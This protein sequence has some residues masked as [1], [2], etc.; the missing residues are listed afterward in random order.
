MNPLFDNTSFL[1]HVR[2][3]VSHKKETEEN[4]VKKLNQ[5][6]YQE[7]IDLKKARKRADMANLPLYRNIGFTVAFLLVIVV[8]NWRSPVD[9][10]VDLGTLEVNAEE[11]IDIPISEQ[12]PPPPPKTTEV[13]RIVEVENSVELEELELIIDVEAKEESEVEVI[14]ADFE[15]EDEVEVVE[16]I[17]TIVEE[18]PE[19]VGGME[20]FFKYVAES[21]EY[22]KAASRL[23]VSGRVFMQ[24]VVEKDGSITDIKVLKGIGAGCDEEAIRVLSEAP[25]WKPGKQRG[26]PVRVYKMLPIHFRLVE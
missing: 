21:L 5:D 20:A 13:A 2:M 16:E 6:Q 14:V 7:L 24:F 11:I 4:Q 19:P 25:K 1:Q 8:F 26:Q 17:F 15:P 9:T 23:H 3:H 18:A 10:L 12:P 22:P